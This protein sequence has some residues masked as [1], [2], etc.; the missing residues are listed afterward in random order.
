[1]LTINLI[2]TMEMVITLIVDD[3]GNAQFS[4][5]SQISRRWQGFSESPFTASS[6]SNVQ[7]RRSLSVLLNFSLL[8]LP[9]LYL[10]TQS[11]FLRFLSIR[12]LGTLINR[13]RSL[14]SH[15]HST[16]PQDAAHYSPPPGLGRSLHSHL[17]QASRVS[18]LLP[19]QCHLHRVHHP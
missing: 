2:M 11:L 4:R 18:H 19:S 10:I 14:L 17:H 7:S 5:R 15:T 13:P 8:P 16:N 3:D 6:I 1:M 12:S 9:I